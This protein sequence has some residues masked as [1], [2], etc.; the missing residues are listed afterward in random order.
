MRPPLLTAATLLLLSLTLLLSLSSS[1]VGS[2]A[3]SFPLAF[4][5]IR[6]C[7]CD[8]LETHD[9]NKRCTVCV[10]VWCMRPNTWSVRFRVAFGRKRKMCVC[11]FCVLHSQSRRRIRMVYGSSDDVWCVCERNEDG[12]WMRRRIIKWMKQSFVCR[13]TVRTFWSRRKTGMA[14]STVETII[15]KS[16]NTLHG[17][18]CVRGHD[19]DAILVE[20]FDWWQWPERER[21]TKVRK[22]AFD[23]FHAMCGCV[24]HT[25]TRTQS[26][27]LTIWWVRNVQ[28]TIRGRQ[29]GAQSVFLNCFFDCWALRSFVCVCARLP[30]C[31]QRTDEAG[32]FVN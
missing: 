3:S 26:E 25:H 11:F 5:G 24:T 16:Q 4:T 8:F 28:R 15:T 30:T 9:E 31:E 29:C 2:F 6:C 17:C 1:L 10:R 20:S 18:E 19:D 32:T 27:L 7:D 21:E 22:N 14:V 13:C 12:W 23:T